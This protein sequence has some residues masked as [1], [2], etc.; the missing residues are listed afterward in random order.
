MRKKFNPQIYLEIAKYLKDN[1]DLNLEGR[2][3]CAVGRA[4]YAAFLLIRNKL[5][6]KGRF[7]DKNRQHKEVR[8]YLKILNQNFLA[9]QLET[10][11]NYRVSADY[12]LRAEFN[13]ATCD[14]C[15]IISEEIIN[16]IES[17]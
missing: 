16:S 8:E 11:F 15:L 3:R 7:F 2:I 10:L 12:K 9:N 14:K 17:L 1:N 6:Q 5:K 13:D 4:Y